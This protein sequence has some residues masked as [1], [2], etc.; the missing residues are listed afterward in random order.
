[1]PMNDPWHCLVD[2]E[3]LEIGPAWEGVLSGLSFV[4]WLPHSGEEHAQIEEDAVD[5]PWTFKSMALGAMFC[6]FLAQGVVWAYLFLIG[7]AGGLGEQ[8]VANGLTLSQ[9]AGIAGA[10]LAAIMAHRF[11]RTMPL[12]EIGRAHV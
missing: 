2:Y 11:G 8:A 4:R 9:F 10:M 5:L 12:T 1:M 3:S 6:Y 7:M